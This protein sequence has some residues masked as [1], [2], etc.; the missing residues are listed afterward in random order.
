[1]E[2]EVEDLG[3]M[4]QDGSSGLLTI[5]EVT[6]AQAGPYQCTANNGIAPPASVV[7]QLVVR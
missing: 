6:R 5:Y 4:S 1:G 7:G 2:G 3:E